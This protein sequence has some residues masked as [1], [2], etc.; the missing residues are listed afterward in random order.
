VPKKSRPP[1]IETEFKPSTSADKSIRSAKIKKPDDI[2]GV[3][4]TLSASQSSADEKRKIRKVEKGDD[5][6]KEPETPTKNKTMFTDLPD[7]IGRSSMSKLSNFKI[8]KVVDSEA[9]SKNVEKE[10]EPERPK[11]EKSRESSS[12]HREQRHESS[13]DRWEKDDKREG[14]GHSSDR[15]DSYTND[16]SQ[17][18]HYH[19]G[20]GSNSYYSGRGKCHSSSHRNS[21]YEESAYNE[22]GSSSHFRRQRGNVAKQGGQYDDRY[23]PSSPQHT[24]GKSRSQSHFPPPHHKRSITDSGER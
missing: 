13:R 18:D 17:R 14:Y 16:S 10:A 2:R 21:N 11:E 19:S 24:S 12:S 5:K 15:R 3:K 6:S 22:R 23:N 4:R 1:I 20:R 7:F 9:T 8:P